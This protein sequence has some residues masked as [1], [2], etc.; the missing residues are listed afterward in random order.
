MKKKVHRKKARLQNMGGGQEMM[1]FDP[2]F[3]DLV[4]EGGSE[5][6]YNGQKIP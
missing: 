3:H 1:F 2:P 4:M 5:Q 6:K